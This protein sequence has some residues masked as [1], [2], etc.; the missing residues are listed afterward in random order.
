[1]E[2]SECVFEAREFQLILLVQL[3]G[4]DD[5]VCILPHPIMQSCQPMLNLLI[6]MIKLLY[7]VW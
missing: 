6:N 2:S 4:E 7:S 5:E 3:F 1:M